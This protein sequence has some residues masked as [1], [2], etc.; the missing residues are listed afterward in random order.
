MTYK[1]LCTLT[2]SKK[3]LAGDIVTE[4]ELNGFLELYLSNQS[5]EPIIEPILDQET[6]KTTKSKTTN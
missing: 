5:I 4:L 2:L 6:S 1:V 3:Y